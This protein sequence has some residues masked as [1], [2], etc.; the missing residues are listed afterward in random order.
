M[1]TKYRAAISFAVG[2]AL[3]YVG[4]LS[5]IWY[6][7]I[8]CGA[9]VGALVPLRWHHQAACL[10]GAGVASNLIYIAPL[11]GDGLL[12]LM[13]TVGEIIGVGDDLLLLVMLLLSG[14]MVAAGGAI[15]GSAADLIRAGRHVDSPPAN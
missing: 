12:R 3:G 4:L 1:R 6:A 11:F 7:L 9:I 13:N 10:F 15:G 14:A 2:V 5:G 8:L